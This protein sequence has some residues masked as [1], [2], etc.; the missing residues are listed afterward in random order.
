[1]RFKALALAVAAIAATPAVAQTTTNPDGT[2][3]RR[4]T[5]T[6]TRN[7][8]YF[9]WGLLG[10]LGLAGLMGRRRHDDVHT[11]TTHTGHTDRGVNRTNDTT[12]L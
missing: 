8:T 9:P 10:L 11:H 4:T 12:R 7:E 6:E 3:V 5:N 2:V 1:M